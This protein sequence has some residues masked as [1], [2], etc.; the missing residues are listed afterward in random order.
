MLFQRGGNRFLPHFY[1]ANS[2]KDS[3]CL[4]SHY[5]EIKDHG[6][7]LGLNL[8]WRSSPTRSHGEAINLSPIFTT[9]WKERRSWGG[10]HSL[11]GCGQV[12]SALSSTGFFYGVLLHSFRLNLRL[13]EPQLETGPLT[14]KLE[15][16]SDMYT[17]GSLPFQS[18][19]IITLFYT[20]P[21]PDISHV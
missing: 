11:K 20:L 4:A 13:S 17:T 6:E 14:Q 5:S 3:F 10:Y 9:Y 8:C 1:P 15:I 2:P 18:S 7:E 21:S 12:A 16:P 19:N